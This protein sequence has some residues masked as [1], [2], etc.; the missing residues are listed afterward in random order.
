VPRPN[1]GNYLRI[2]LFE[3]TLV[4]KQDFSLI[5]RPFALDFV[6]NVVV[7]I[8]SFLFTLLAAGEK[9]LVYL[10]SSRRSALR[11]FKMKSARIF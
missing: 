10:N 5:F 9:Q 4:A 11:Q 6:L 7:L 2:S 8:H 3:S 1:T